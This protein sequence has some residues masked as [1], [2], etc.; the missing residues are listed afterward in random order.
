VRAGDRVHFTGT[1]IGNPLSYPAPTGLRGSDA[2]LLA[3]QAAHLA[4][5]TSRIWVQR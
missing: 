2:A 3:R 5:S 4:V 1:L